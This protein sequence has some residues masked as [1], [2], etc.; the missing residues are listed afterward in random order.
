MVRKHLVNAGC[1]IPEYAREAAGD[2][3]AKKADKQVYVSV[4]V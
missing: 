3:T 2:K 1:M 4:R